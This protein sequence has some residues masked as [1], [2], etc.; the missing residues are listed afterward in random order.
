MRTQIAP[1]LTR[2]KDFDRFWSQTLAELDSVDFGLEWLTKRRSDDGELVHEEFAFDSLGGARVWA[3]LLRVRNG[4]S[5]P[6]VVHAHGYGSQCEIQWQWARAG[7]NVCG[8][9]VRGFGRSRTALADRSRWGY[10]LT[11]IDAPEHH[12]LRGAVCDYL[13]VAR[14]AREL[15]DGSLSRLVLTGNS[16][17]GGLALM[18][19]AL[20]PAAHLLVVGVPTFGWAEGRQFFVRSGS[21]REINDYLA[22]RPDHA[23][24]VMTVL[25]YFDPINFAPMVRCSTLVGVGLRD[26]V[27]PADTVY[28]VANHM[29]GAHEIMELPVSHSDSPEAQHWER[30][31]RYWMRLTLEGLPQDFGGERGRHIHRFT[32]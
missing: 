25:R 30:F 18:A 23:E 20:A 31:E 17:A 26:D 5:R 2:P 14:V 13:R 29:T 7:V 21:G 22:R 1:P 9:D 24:D 15:L 12:V 8:V 16:F 32:S 19:E 10:L 27:V 11:G 3:Y 6:L 28:A 4:S